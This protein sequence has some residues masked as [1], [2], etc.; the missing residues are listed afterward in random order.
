MFLKKIFRFFQKFPG[1]EMLV[2][3]GRGQTGAAL[4]ALP[5]IS[6]AEFGKEYV[7]KEKLGDSRPDRAQL[8]RTFVRSAL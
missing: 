8:Q 1:S 7:H 3:H 5:Q 6:P 4:V 2:F